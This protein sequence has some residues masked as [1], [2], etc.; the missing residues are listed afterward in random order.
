M[1]YHNSSESRWECWEFELQAKWGL[2]KI[3][4]KSGC[5][6]IWKIKFYIKTTEYLTKP[7]WTNFIFLDICGQMWR[8]QKCCQIWKSFKFLHMRSRNLKFIF[9]FVAKSVYWWFTMFCREIHFVAIS[10]VLCGEKF[11]KKLWRKKWQIWVMANGYGLV[12]RSTKWE[13]CF[14]FIWLP[15]DTWEF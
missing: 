11:I 5:L 9:I 4:T 6:Y 8:N 12:H 3:R 15:Y 14:L 2:P 13:D 10:A 1:K 7:L